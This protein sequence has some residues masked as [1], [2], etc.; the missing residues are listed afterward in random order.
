MTN[1]AFKYLDQAQIIL[2]RIRATQMDAIERAAEIC[3]QT[4]AGDGLV[5]LFGT[6]HSRIFVEEMFP[7][8]GSFPVF[9][10]SLNSRSPTTTL[11]SARTGSARPCSWKM[12]AAWRN[13]F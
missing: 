6:G 3:T 11:W 12:P 5:H 7:R 2:N 8:H 1:S 4:I 10:P 9:I 13:A